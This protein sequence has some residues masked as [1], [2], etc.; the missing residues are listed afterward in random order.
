MLLRPVS[1]MQQRMVRLSPRRQAQPSLIAAIRLVVIDTM[2]YQYAPSWSKRH[3]MV[4][5]IDG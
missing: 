4:V 5:D 2:Q 3:E 1:D